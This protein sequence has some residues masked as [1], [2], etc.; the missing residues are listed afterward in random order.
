MTLVCEMNGLLVEQERNSTGVCESKRERGRTVKRRDSWM[1][2]ERNKDGMEDEELTRLKN[3]INEIVQPWEGC[4]QG[5][6]SG[7]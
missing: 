4:A 1:K 2:R 5:R 3:S 7:T 6:R